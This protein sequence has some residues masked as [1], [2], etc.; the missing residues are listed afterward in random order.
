MRKYADENVVVMLVGNKSDL[1]GYRQ[2]SSELAVNFAST[3][4]LSF[5]HLSSKCTLQTCVL[6][7]HNLSFI[8]TSALDSSNVEKAFTDVVTGNF[9]LIGLNHEYFAR[10]V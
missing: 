2:V 9:L 6:G 3:G 10:L 4:A 5:A 1:G 7:E 8:E